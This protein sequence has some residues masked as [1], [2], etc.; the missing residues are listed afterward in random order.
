MAALSHISLCPTPYYSQAVEIVER[1]GIGHP[2]TIC[3][4]LAEELS[5]K[6]CE[7]YLD[8]FGLVLHHNVDKALLWG[9]TSQPKFGGG[10]IILPMEIFLAGRAT[11]EYKG[12]SVPIEEMVEQSCTRWLKSNIHALDTEHHIKLHSLIRPG[13]PDLVELYLRQQKTGIALANDTSCGVG[14]APFSEM[15]RIVLQV[16]QTLNAAETKAA[17]PETGEDIKVMAIRHVNDI[18]LT[19]SCAFID[20]YISD[21]DDYV[22]KKSQLAKLVEKTAATVSN[23]NIN[24][25]VNAADDVKADSLYMTVTGTSAESGDDGEVGRGNRVNGLITPYRPMNM[26]AAAG[27]N[28]VT[29]V[30]KLYNIVAQ[31][32]AHALVEELD[33]VAEAYCYLVSRIGSPIKEPRIIDIRVALVEG[34]SIDA[35]QQSI[36]EIVQQKLETMDRIRQLLVSGTMT[37]Y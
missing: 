34:G 23:K 19:V 32:I 21:V 2:D 12:V 35:M 15:E 36:D 28:P 29:H 7:F 1:K 33:E 31:Q 22:L 27:K 6:L 8:N 37:V 9:G 18:E 20:R 11:S 25:T 17:H 14:Y 16:E 24:V 13:S 3:D 30:G 10:K 5:R 4:A 26:E